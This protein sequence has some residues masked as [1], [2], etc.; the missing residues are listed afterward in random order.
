MPARFVNIDRDT[1][2]LLAPNLRGW[3]PDNQLCHFIVDAVG[4]VE[5]VLA[6][7]GFYSEEAVKE[8]ETSQG[9]A[10]SGTKVNAAVEKSSHPR[11]VQDLEKKPE[12]EAPAPGAPVAEVMKHRLRTREGKARYKRRQQAVEPVFG[13]IQRVMGFP[14]FLFR[15]LEKA[16]TEW[17]W[18]SLA[19]NLNRMHR[20]QW[21]AQKQ[22]R[23]IKQTGF[24]L[25]VA[26]ISFLFANRL[27]LNLNRRTL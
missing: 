13:I 7:S 21:A 11:T 27:R 2:P 18:V 12:P 6:D 15:G 10:D 17:T 19:Y 8:V 9:G 1:P 5:A 24:C 26:A 14:R 25:P 23:G 20:M 16:S 22:P 4:R 3:V